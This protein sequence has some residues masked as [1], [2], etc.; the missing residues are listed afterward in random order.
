MVMHSNDGYAHHG[1]CMY[2]NDGY[3]PTV[4]G[5]LNQLVRLAASSQFLSSSFKLQA[6]TQLVHGL[7]VSKRLCPTS[8]VEATVS[9]FKRRAAPRVRRSL[10]KVESPLQLRGRMVSVRRAGRWRPSICHDGEQ[11]GIKRT[12][13]RRKLTRLFQHG[14][15]VKESKRFIYT[16]HLHR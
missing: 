3:A 4:L 14:E 15:G 5:Q 7:K 9:D 11:C 1:C 12:H 13:T 2:S 8:N 6:T 16:W 10:R